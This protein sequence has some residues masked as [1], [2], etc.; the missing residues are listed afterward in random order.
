MI[1]RGPALRHKEIGRQQLLKFVEGCS[2]FGDVE[3]PPRMEGR[4]MTM[5]LRPKP[6]N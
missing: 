1:F 2:E 5:L 4:R 6:T 3:Q